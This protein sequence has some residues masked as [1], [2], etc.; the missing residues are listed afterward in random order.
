L[1][2][3]GTTEERKQDP[4]PVPGNGH[5]K[6]EEEVVLSTGQLTLLNWIAVHCIQNKIFLHQFQIVLMTFLFHCKSCFNGD[7]VSNY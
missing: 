1:Q 4:G 7:K 6:A 5:G 2:Q 3:R